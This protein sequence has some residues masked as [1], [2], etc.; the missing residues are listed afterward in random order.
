MEIIYHNKKVEELSLD[1]KKATKKAFLL[2][3]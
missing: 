3:L 2:N 1:I